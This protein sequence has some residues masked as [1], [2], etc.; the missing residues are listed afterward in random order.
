MIKAANLRCKVGW[1]LG[2]VKFGDG[3]DPAFSL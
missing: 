2:G 1:E 3:H